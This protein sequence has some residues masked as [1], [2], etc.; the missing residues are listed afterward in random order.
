MFALSAIDGSTLLMV[1][2]ALTSIRG[3]RSLGGCAIGVTD[4]RVLLR[5]SCW[6]RRRKFARLD[7]FFKIVIKVVSFASIC[8]AFY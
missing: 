4:H 7:T 2:A 1:R 6:Y 3:S 5:L 8:V